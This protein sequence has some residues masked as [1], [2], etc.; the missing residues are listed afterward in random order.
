MFYDNYGRI[1]GRNPIWLHGIL[2]ILMRMFYWFGMYTN[3]GNTKA[4]T[5][6]PRFIWGQL[7]KD[8][9]KRRVMGEAANFQERNNVKLQQVWRN[10]GGVLT[11][12]PH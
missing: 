2:T 1:S 6:T 3:L 9:Y 10:G 8:S 12:A 4:M 7:V 5:C 11:L